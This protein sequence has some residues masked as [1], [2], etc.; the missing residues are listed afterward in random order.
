MKKRPIF[1]KLF[2]RLQ[3]PRN[4]IQ[5][6]LG[7]R[8][9]GKTTLALQVVDE[10]KKPCHY[11]SADFATLQDLV[12]LQQ[13]WEIARQK[14]KHHQ[15]CL[16]IIDEIQKIPHWSDI[17]KGLWDQDTRNKI[18]LSVMILGS[19][20]W[21]MQKGLSESL[22]GRFE[23]IPITHWSYEEMRRIFG[24][25]LDKYL[26]FGGY[27]GAAPFANEDI[28]LDGLIILMN[29]LLKPVFA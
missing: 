3:E 17:V 11:I 14:A 20:P 5:V 19:S 13:Q 22:A 24:W 26:Y 18:N 4:F 7:P 27:P 28:H 23:V 15:H 29:L 25:S 10:I 6:L 2:E 21:L 8:Q 12:W 16:L 9:V 1:K